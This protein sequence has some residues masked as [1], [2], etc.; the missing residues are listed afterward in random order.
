MTRFGMIAVLGAASAAHAANYAG[1]GATGFGGPVGNGSLDV[2]DTA[3][4]LTVTANRGGGGWNDA[5]VVYLDTQAGGF[6]D[7]STLVDNNDGGRTAISGVTGNG[8]TTAFFPAGFGADYAM[9]IENG[10]F[11]VF[12]ISD[13][14][15]PPGHTFLFGAPQSGNNLAPSYSITLDASQMAQIGLTAGSGQTFGLVGTYISP[16]GYRSNETIGASVTVPGN[17]GGDPNNAGFTGTVTFSAANSY[18]L[19]VPE[20]ASFALVGLGALG[21]LARRRK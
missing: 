20:P 8:R 17:P 7:T 18:S 2:T 19:V 21:V 11:G 12:Q 4:S 13:Q 5:L 14:A 9:V 10:Y 6:G 1:N 3:S 15:F 16:S